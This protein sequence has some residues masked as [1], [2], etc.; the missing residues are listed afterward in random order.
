MKDGKNGWGRVWRRLDQGL[1]RVRA[2]GDCI[3]DFDWCRRSDLKRSRIV[4]SWIFAGYIPRECLDGG[5]RCL[6]RL[7]EI[8]RQVILS[9]CFRAVPQESA[10]Q[11]KSK[12]SLGNHVEEEEEGERL[13]VYLREAFNEL[14]YTT[15][16]Q[17][18]PTQTAYTKS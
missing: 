1:D 6:K 3:G 15:M 14:H 2:L 5:T 18:L 10:Q 13:C 9:C 16:F 17:A 4:D 11:C 12:E 8:Y 7:L